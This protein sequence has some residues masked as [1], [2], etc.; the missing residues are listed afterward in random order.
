M[1]VYDQQM[2]RDAKD[3]ADRASRESAQH[4][5]ALLA[6]QARVEKLALINQ[7][8]WTLVQEGTG[9]TDSELVDRVQQLRRENEK[10]AQSGAA[11][12]RAC[13]KCH[14][15]VATGQERCLYCG[16]E[17]VPESIFNQF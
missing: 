5:S 14:R 17:V 2:V 6:L 9:K 4:Y 10:R 8:L 16:A 1:N 12:F 3:V 11:S 15:S 13:E 7:A